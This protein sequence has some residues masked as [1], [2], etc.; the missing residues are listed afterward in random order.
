MRVSQH[1][2]KRFAKGDLDPRLAAVA[3]WLSAAKAQ[4]RNV[5]HGQNQ[6]LSLTGKKERIEYGRPGLGKTKWARRRTVGVRRRGYDIT[7]R[8]QPEAFNIT[9]VVLDLDAEDS[10]YVRVYGT[11]RD[12]SGALRFWNDRRRQEGIWNL[13]PK[14]DALV[15]R[16]DEFKYELRDSEERWYAPVK[17]FDPRRISSRDILQVALL[18]P[19]WKSEE[20]QKSVGEGDRAPEA[21]GGPAKVMDMVDVLRENGIP[22]RVLDDDIKTLRFMFAWQK[23]HPLGQQSDSTTNSDSGQPL[24]PEQSLD[25]KQEPDIAQ[26][27]ARTVA[28]WPGLNYLRRSLASL[29][30]RESGE[31]FVSFWDDLREGGGKSPWSLQDIETG[32]QRFQNGLEKREDPIEALS[33][34]NNMA[35][36]LCARNSYLPEPLAS[37]AIELAFN[38]GNLSAVPAFLPG[39]EWAGTIPVEAGYRFLREPEMTAGKRLELFTILT[40][41]G[42]SKKLPHRPSAR[43]SISEN[44]GHMDCEM[45]FHLL[46]RLGAVRTLWHEWHDPRYPSKY[47][48]LFGDCFDGLL[49]YRDLRRCQ[50][51]PGVVI[52]PVTGDMAEDMYLDARDMARFTS[53][54]VFK[55]YD[56]VGYHVYDELRDECLRAMDLKN[57]EQAMDTLGE[58]L[59]G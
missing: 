2:A 7:K 57:I 24:G 59:L 23:T 45:Y 51:Q 18:G 49:H 56:L 31:E 52:A 22:D 26:P 20:S 14:L 50:Q 44:S 12:E 34:L 3:G 28:P 29:L 15:E 55:E 4:A 54:P 21:G 1:L 16:I 36:N 5:V 6:A 38:T 30:E 42:L 11:R 48:K 13:D 39:N 40:G 35:L 19:R 53:F 33:F 46:G 17:P 43:P 37:V 27:V 10:P 58:L 41:Q 25:S 8:V 32:F 47:E 9:N